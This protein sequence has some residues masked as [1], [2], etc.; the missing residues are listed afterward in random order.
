VLH[1]GRL[2][3]V[4]EPLALYERP[5]NLFVAGF[6]GSPPMNLLPGAVA[7][8]AGR[9]V[10][11]AAAAAGAAPLRIPLDDALARRA[12]PAAGSPLVFGIRPEDLA[13]EPG[14][15]PA[16]VDVVEP[17]GAETYLY[18]NTPAGAC[19]AR[20]PAGGRYRAGDQVPLG[21]RTARAHLFDAATGRALP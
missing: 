4:A 9:P 21:F 2:Q 3:Q 6:I 18:L 13:V 17:L 11:A 5:A 7:T 19:T 16:V 14:G 20:V 12:A 10:F 1:A 15:C 8:D